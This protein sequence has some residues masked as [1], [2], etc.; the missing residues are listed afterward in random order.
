MSEVNNNIKIK[1]AIHSADI[2]LKKLDLT[3]IDL[4]SASGWGVIDFF[5]GGLFSTLMKH[6]DMNDAEIHLKEAKT[7]LKK[8][9]DELNDLDKLLDVD[10]DTFNFLG[11]ADVFMDCVISDWL[12][13]SQIANAQNQVDLAIKKVKEIKE[14]LEETINNNHNE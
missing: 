5:G 1:E 11:F 14:K 3:K 13:Q 2:A 6:S 8:F 4:K 9:N 12:V 7:A 10:V